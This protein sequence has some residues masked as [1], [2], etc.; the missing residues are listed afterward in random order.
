[1]TKRTYIGIVYT[2]RYINAINMYQSINFEHELVQS[3]DL[4]ESYRFNVYSKLSSH[5]HTPIHT[6]IV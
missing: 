1:M 2:I 5:V 3:N 4:G 6:L